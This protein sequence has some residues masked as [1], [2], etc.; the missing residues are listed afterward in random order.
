MYNEECPFCGLD[1]YEYVDTG[2]GLQAVAVS[3][4]EFGIS[5]FDWRIKDVVID[6]IGDLLMGDK[7]R[8]RRGKR[9]RKK[10]EAMIKHYEE[11]CLEHDPDTTEPSNEIPFPF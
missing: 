7:R 2:V 1:P 5:Y 4:C 6:R 10:Y 9:L 8:Q 3:C 11:Q